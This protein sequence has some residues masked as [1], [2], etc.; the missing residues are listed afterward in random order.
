MRMSHGHGMG[1]GPCWLRSDRSLLLH[2]T[3]SNTISQGTGTRGPGPGH[4]RAGP[5]PVAVRSSDEW[6][7]T[8]VAVPEAGYTGQATGYPA[9]GTVPYRVQES[10][11]RNHINMQG[12]IREKIG[13]NRRNL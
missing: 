7:P 3:G 9:P 5:V 13:E 8:V 10:T 4:P 11:G 6:L 1:M 12:I 2:C